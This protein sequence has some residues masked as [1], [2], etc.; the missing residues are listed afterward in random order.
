MAMTLN[1][2]INTIVY[3]DLPS[4]DSPEKT[5]LYE[6]GI[7]VQNPL[8]NTIANAP[9]FTCDLPYWRDL[10]EATA[11][12]ISN[13]TVAA[14]A[15]PDLIDQGHQTARKAL[16]NQGWSV[17]DLASEV[18]MGAG[19]AMERI[20]NRVDKYWSR[21]W[22]RRIIASA[23]GVLAGNVLNDASDMVMN[24]AGATNADVNANTVFSRNNFTSAA[25]T[26]GD[27]VDGIGLIAVHSVVYKRMIDNGDIIMI[28]PQDGSLDVPTYL[29]K[30][31]IVDDSMPVTPAA[32][33]LPGDAAPRYTSIL[34][35]SGAFG[36]GEGT[37]DVPVEV[38]RS[39]RTGNGAGQE[40][41]WVRKTWLLHP[42]GFQV[43]VAPAGV[44]YTLAELALAASWTRVVVRKH[45]PL[46]FLVTN[47]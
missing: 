15:V 37:P 23:N 8:L 14:V 35:G 18:A 22:Q 44:S 27:A 38:E 30:R 17:M 28:R 1:E 3:Q 2:I 6:S 9:G 21:Q 25:F 4:L 39:A 20:K 45:V 19:T 24:V 41:L 32:G 10:N 31:V 40:T 33:P 16:L 46:A 42:F 11:P 26:M 5:A 47:G 36:Y 43:G 29:G 34:F 7:V 12:N 13:A